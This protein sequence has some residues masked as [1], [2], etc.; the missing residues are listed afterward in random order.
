MQFLRS[1]FRIQATAPVT[2]HENLVWLRCARNHCIVSFLF[3]FGDGLLDLSKTV[4]TNFNN[5]YGY[6]LINRSDLT[7]YSLSSLYTKQHNFVQ[8]ALFA[9]IF[10]TFC[11]PSLQAKATVCL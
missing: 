8:D 1:L 6:Q 9:L 4:D 5:I 10:C 11:Y 7:F 3:I 2:V